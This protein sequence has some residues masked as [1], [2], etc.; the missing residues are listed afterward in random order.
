MISWI[1]GTILG[2]YV[3]VLL[4]TFVL[5][6]VLKEEPSWMKILDQICAPAVELGK[7]VTKMIFGDKKF[8][9]DMP[10]LMG[11]LTVFVGSAVV[12][13]VLGIIGL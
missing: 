8:D 13:T 1:V 6:L 9:F 3:L 2:L 11:A 12:C 10:L 7:L 5:K 4:V